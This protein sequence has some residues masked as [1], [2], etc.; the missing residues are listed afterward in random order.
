MRRVLRS[1]A[2]VE[3]R[4]DWRMSRLRGPLVAGVQRP[5]ILRAQIARFRLEA[6]REAPCCSRRLV[7]VAAA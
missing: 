2:P 7:V 1:V 3:T 6:R 5:S 4:M